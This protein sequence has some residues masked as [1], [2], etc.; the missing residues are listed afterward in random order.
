MDGRI[1]ISQVMNPRRTRNTR[2]QCEHG[3]ERNTI[4]SLS[5]QQGN[6][7]SGRA[8]FEQDMRRRHWPLV[9]TFILEER[10]KG[11]HRIERAWPKLEAVMRFM[12]Q[13]L[14]ILIE[15]SGSLV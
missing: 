11:E 15:P 10:L 12:R 5:S 14:A 4:D 13:L 3:R 1:L 2:G 7:A 6:G 9:D 8:S